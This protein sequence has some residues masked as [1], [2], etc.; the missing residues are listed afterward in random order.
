VQSFCQLM[1]AYLGASVPSIDL[2]N[3][4]HSRQRYFLHPGSEDSRRGVQKEDRT[5]CSN[6]YHP[7]KAHLC[8][9]NHEVSQ[10][11]YFIVFFFFSIPFIDRPAP[12]PFL[13]Q[14]SH[15]LFAFKYLLNA[16]VSISPYYLPPCPLS[17]RIMGLLSLASWLRHL[18]PLLK[19][20]EPL[21][22]QVPK[23]LG[24]SS[25]LTIAT[26]LIS[27]HIQR[28]LWMSMV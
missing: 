18:L 28:M 16:T 25:G 6:H 26:R 4:S 24:R 8:W 27:C 12:C 7:A 15:E 2:K 5:L 3:R 22:P 13:I 21:A 1:G 20:V 10:I 19:M 23:H 17:Q 14:T 9:N 11:S